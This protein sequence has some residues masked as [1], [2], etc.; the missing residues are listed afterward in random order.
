NKED[1]V[2]F[3]TT[4]KIALG[5]VFAA[6]V[7]AGTPVF[8]DDEPNLAGNMNEVILGPGD[9]A[10]APVMKPKHGAPWK[11]GMSHFG[12]SNTWTIQMAHDAE[13]EASKHPEIGQFLLRN[14]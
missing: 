14:A 9:N 12:L 4:K 13:Y 11:I 5:T 1:N 10:M 8:A 7:L 3:S 6:M 2:M